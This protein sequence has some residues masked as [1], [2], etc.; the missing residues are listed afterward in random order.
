[1]ETEIRVIW[2]HS[3]GHLQPTAAENDEEWDLLRMSMETQSS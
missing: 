3:Q 1:M 2:P